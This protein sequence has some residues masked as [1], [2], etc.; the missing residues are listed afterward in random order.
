MSYFQQRPQVGGLLGDFQIPDYAAGVRSAMAQN[1]ATPKPKKDLW[2]LGAIGDAMQAFNGQE[3][4]YAAAMAQKQQAEME[5]QQRQRARVEGMEDFKTKEQ[6][7]RENQAPYIPDDEKRAQYYEK[8]G[9]FNT[10]KDIRDRVGLIPVQR[11]NPTT[12]D[13][14]TVM[15]R[16]GL[17]MDGVSSAP[18]KAPQP[19]TVEDGFMFKG[20]DPADPSSWEPVG[21]GAGLGAPRPFR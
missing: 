17:L 2:W 13:V 16:P 6:Y 3:G 14:E 4:T 8:I 7:H 21:G 11:L 19:G 1:A 20:G 18:M 15:V 10:A 12:Q 5:E 9:D